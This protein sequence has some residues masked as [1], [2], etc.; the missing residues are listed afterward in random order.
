MRRATRGLPGGE[1]GLGGGAPPPAFGFPPP[2][3][4]P[5]PPPPPGGYAKIARWLF[6]LLTSQ[7]GIG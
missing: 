5:P 1:G 4:S 2:P 6:T 7:A 3:F